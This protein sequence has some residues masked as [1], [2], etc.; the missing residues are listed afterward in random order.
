MRCASA[1]AARSS[2]WGA[3]R[4]RARGRDLDGA[5]WPDPR[6]QRRRPHR[7]ARGRR[8]AGRGPGGVRAAG[9]DARARPAARRR[10]ARDRR[11]RRRDRRLRARCA[12]ATA[13]RATSWSASRWRCPTARVAKAGGKVIK[14]VAG[15]DLAKLF[16][17]LV[18]DARRRSRGLAC[19]CTR[20]PAGHGHRAARGRRPASAS[21]RP[22]QLAPRA[23]RAPDASTSRWADGRGRGPRPAS[24]ARRRAEQARAAAAS[25]ARAPGSTPRAR[26]GRRRSCGTPSAPAQRRRGGRCVQRV[27]GVAVTDLAGVLLRRGRARCE[28][29]CRA[30]R[31]RARRGSPLRADAADGP[32]A[33]RDALAPRAAAWCSTRRTCASGAGPVG[34]PGRGA[35]SRSWGG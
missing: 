14:N 29:R 26:R 34:R 2:R 10:R 31:P 35:R 4:R 19:A 6:A 20:V 17:G 9:P 18:R 1:A 21:P 27:A 28:P 12:T 30:G 25:M 8:A 5:A 13:A 33:L 32:A 7:G 3:P 24:A 11:R 16:A 22:P 23:A 15:Y